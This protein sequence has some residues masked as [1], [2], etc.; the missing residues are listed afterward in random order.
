MNTSLNLYELAYYFFIYSILGWFMESAINTVK[1]KNFINRGFL[2]GP[3]CPIYGVGMC[4]IY[5]CCFP[6]RYHLFLVFASGMCLATL[7]EYLTGY[8]MEKLFSAKWWDYSHLKYN[9]HGY[10][11][12]HISIAWGLLSILFISFLHPIIQKFVLMLPLSMGHIV[13]ILLGLLFFIDCI[14]STYIALKLRSKLPA[15]AT[16]RLELITLLE[17]SKLYESADE[18]KTH[19]DIQ[20]IADKLN[21]LIDSLKEHFPQNSELTLTQLHELLSLKFKNY[22][23]QLSKFSISEKRLLKAFPTLSLTPIKALKNKINKRGSKK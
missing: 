15:L 21:T 12:L 20:K 18:F 22:H 19:F 1:Q 8:M 14:Y 16:L 13:L 9:L 23:T 7:L 3:Y 11:C 6:I 4:S 2:V 10:I 17:Q 5:L